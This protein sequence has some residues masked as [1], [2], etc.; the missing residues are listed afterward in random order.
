MMLRRVAYHKCIDIHRWT[1]RRPVV[2]LE[3]A[4]DL[5]YEDEEQA[6]EQQT[7]RMEEHAHLRALLAQLPEQ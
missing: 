7:L 1:Q 2:P 3:S 4:L 6:P 5:F